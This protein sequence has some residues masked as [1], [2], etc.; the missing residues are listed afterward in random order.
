MEGVLSWGG[1][2]CGDQPSS[3][4]DARVRVGGVWGGGAHDVRAEAGAPLDA[5]LGRTKVFSDCE[6]QSPAVGE[7]EDTLDKALAIGGLAKQQGVPVIV[8]GR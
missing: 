4:L 6:F 8:H 7:G 3:T 1:S 5:L 2:R